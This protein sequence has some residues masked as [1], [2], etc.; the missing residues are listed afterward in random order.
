MAA[1]PRA[2]LRSLCHSRG[3]IAG[4]SSPSHDY[5]AVTCQVKTDFDGCVRVLTQWSRS[6]HLLLNSVNPIGWRAETQLRDRRS[7]RLER[8]HLIVPGGNLANSAPQGL[9]EMPSWA[10][11]P[12][13]DLRHPGR[14]R[15]SPGA[16]P[17]KSTGHA[18]SV[19]LTGAFE[20]VERTPAHAIRIGIR[21]LAQG[22]GHPG[23]GGWCST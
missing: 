4:A 12:S 6:P 22:R 3:Q 15:Q 23:D 16:L 7:L 5:G 10:W 14:G 11:S 21:I 18:R 20:P 19:R 17:A 2:P 9:P 13:P 1:M 8:D